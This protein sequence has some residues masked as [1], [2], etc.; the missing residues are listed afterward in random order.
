MCGNCRQKGTRSR[1]SLRG[2]AGGAKGGGSDNS[3]HGGVAWPIHS[4]RW[5]HPHGG[6]LAFE[7]RCFA[8]ARVPSCG[9]PGAGRRVVA[10]TAS[11]LPC[12]PSYSF[13]VQILLETR[14]RPR[15]CGAGFSAK[16]QTLKT[17]NV[18]SPAYS[19]S[20]T[21]PVL[22]ACGFVHIDQS[23]IQTEHTIFPLTSHR[24]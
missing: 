2:I 19:C 16:A 4:T 22:R 6:G 5:F 18:T 11:A 23:V 1:G 10:T 20:A 9:R 24:S 3:P 12:A 15:T 7:L 14:S 21:L 17:G 8:V 13:D